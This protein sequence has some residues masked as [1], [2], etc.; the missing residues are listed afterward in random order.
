MIYKRLQVDSRGLE[1]RA[2]EKIVTIRQILFEVVFSIYNPPSLAITS[3]H[4]KR[5]KQ[6]QYSVVSLN[7]KS[8]NK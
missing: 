2:R 4:Q 1:G 8:D 3:S 7:K 6:L 5:K